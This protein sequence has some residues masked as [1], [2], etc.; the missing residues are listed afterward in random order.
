MSGADLTADL[1]A[2]R[3]AGLRHVDDLVNEWTPRLAIGAPTI[4]TYLSENIY[5]F[6]DADC[7]RAIEVFREMAAEIGALPPLQTL[8]VLR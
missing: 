8:N 2:S 6:L 5:Y 7:V 4:R 3:D 1:C